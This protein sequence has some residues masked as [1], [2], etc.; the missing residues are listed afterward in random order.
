MDLQCHYSVPPVAHG[1]V[2]V[3]G[4][5]RARTRRF[6]VWLWDGIAHHKAFAG[7]PPAGLR[8]DLLWEL[9]PADVEKRRVDLVQSM[10]F[11]LC[12][13]VKDEPAVLIDQLWFGESIIGTPLFSDLASGEIEATPQVI[14]AV[15][16][17]HE[18]SSLPAEVQEWLQRHE[19]P[20]E[21]LSP[22]VQGPDNILFEVT[23][24]D[25]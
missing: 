6:R 25:S 11:P 2:Y 8:V 23:T 7:L 20:A 1:H 16:Q 19:V 15:L 10:V 5:V 17:R 4:Q 22:C 18:Y 9:S 14:Q 24:P 12:Y 21:P 13:M 3:L